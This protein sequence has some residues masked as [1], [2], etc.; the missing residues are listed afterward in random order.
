MSWTQ[1]CKFFIEKSVQLNVNVPYTDREFLNLTLPN[2][3][4]T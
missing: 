2:G 1:I 4:K 3:K